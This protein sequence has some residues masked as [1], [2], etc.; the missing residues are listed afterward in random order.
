MASIGSTEIRPLADDNTTQGSGMLDHEGPASPAGTSHDQDSD[1]LFAGGIPES[2]LRIPIAVQV[3]IGTARLPLSRVAQ[4]G[5]G[6]TIP[7]EQKLGSPAAILVNGK[8]VARGEIFV[9]D[10]DGDGGRLG[11]TITEVTSPGTLPDF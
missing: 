7:L 9:L 1:R 3:V 2:V 4:L 5:P 8:E 11:I 10:E 6:S